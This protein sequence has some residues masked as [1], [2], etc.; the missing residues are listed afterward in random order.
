MTVIPL[1]NG[2]WAH[3]GIFVLVFTQILTSTWAASP[4]CAQPRLRKEIRDLTDA[5]WT[6]FTNAVN[7]LKQT[8]R[9]DVFTGTHLQFTA[10]AHN[11]ALFL[12]W[13][14]KFIYELETELLGITGPALTGLPYFDPF[15]GYNPFI[16]GSNRYMGAST[17]CITDGP[18]GN[19][20]AAAGGCV[21]RALNLANVQGDPRTISALITSRTAFTAFANAYELGQHASVHAT[22][23]GHM[24]DVNLSPNDPAF[25]LHHS[26]VDYI[27]YKRQFY[28]VGALYWEYSG[29][30]TPGGI[31]Q[32]TLDTQIPPWNTPVRSVLDTYH[33][34]CVDYQDSRSSIPGPAGVAAAGAPAA[35]PAAAPA[36]APIA[37][38][39][40]GP[41]LVTPPVPVGI[42][43]LVARDLTP[44]THQFNRP[45]R[46]MVTLDR[47]TL[48][49]LRISPEGHARAIE[50]LNDVIHKVNAEGLS[51]GHWQP[52][53]HALA[54][55]ASI[56]PPPPPL[57][58]SDANGSAVSINS[59]FWSSCLLVP[60]IL[61]L[62]RMI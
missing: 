50:F 3:W 18:F 13:H 55:N 2:R 33:T 52:S 19:W 26:H 20:V 22:I 17:G 11:G 39:I 16:T 12:I 53:F 1:K 42:A 37:P 56:P 30:H 62:L 45:I 47:A 61:S 14:R 21:Q 25:Y 8:G 36:G 60:S 29:V 49:K 54:I 38:V 23:G 51:T 40:T 48:Q 57:S 9:W 4:L 28:N 46:D 5:E 35:A 32:V 7:R 27:L 6:A 24:A 34:L 31:G 15:H 59:L 58:N 10:P 43:A 41:P 44:A